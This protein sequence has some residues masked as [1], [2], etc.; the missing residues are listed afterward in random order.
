MDKEKT[1]SPEFRKLLNKT[2]IVGIIFS[3]VTFKFQL[4]Y[5]SEAKIW[6]RS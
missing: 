3:E 4:P 1:V 6:A 2:A 5:L